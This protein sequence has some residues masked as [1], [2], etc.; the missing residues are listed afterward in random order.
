MEAN[1]GAD[2]SAGITHTQ[3][4][5]APMRRRWTTGLVTLLATA[6][7]STGLTAPAQ[8]ASA[9]PRSVSGDGV[10]VSNTGPAC[11]AAA[12]GVPFDPDFPIAIDF[13][14]D[15]DGCL[16]TTTVTS[17]Q[18]PQLGSRL[19][20]YIEKGTERFI[21]KGADSGITFDLT[22][23][24]VQWWIGEP[25]ADGSRQLAGGCIHPVVAPDRG[26][27]VLIENVPPDGG[28]VETVDYHGW[29][30]T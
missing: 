18:T 4:R 22:Y 27:L 7:L 20:K 29:I 14:G 6:P 12:D 2:D 17:V 1:P 10:I 13:S 11:N 30:D 23:T 26:L 25:F 19:Y 5:E 15:L 8:A 9:E 28:P 3:T 21:G 24:V 16:Y